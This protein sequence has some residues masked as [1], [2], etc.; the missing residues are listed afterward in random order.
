MTLIFI[1]GWTRSS[2][3]CAERHRC[4]QIRCSEI[5]TAFS[6][7]STGQAVNSRR[8]DPRQRR[9]ADW[10]CY[11]DTAERYRRGTD[12]LTCTAEPPCRL[13]DR[14]VDW[15]RRRLEC[16]IW[17]DTS[18]LCSLVTD[19]PWQ[20][21]SIFTRS[22]TLSQCSWS[23]ISVDRPRS[24]LRVL[25]TRRAAAFSMRCKVAIKYWVLHWTLR[26]S[27]PPATRWKHARAS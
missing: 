19:V 15:Q 8:S 2:S 22:G 23:W 11:V 25:V 9:P 14:D 20:P 27:S 10:V 26:C 16:S 17:P 6:R 5:R 12:Q 21:A 1:H 24:Y 18:K 13:A 3:M 7:S 4:L